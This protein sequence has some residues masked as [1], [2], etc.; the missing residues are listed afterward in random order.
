MSTPIRT[1][2]PAA[3]A[4]ILSG[5]AITHNI[6]PVANVDGKQLCI[7]EN[8]GV[9]NQAF[10]AT[11]RRVLQERGYTVRMLPPASPVASC[12]LTSTYNA[13]WQQDF[14]RYLAF[15]DLRIFVG[16]QQVGYAIY[17]STGGTFNKDKFIQ[18]DAKIA[19]L[20]GAMLPDAR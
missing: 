5:C 18:D 4:A 20:V 11:Y 12:R 13:S 2:V 15:A 7:V 16:G 10:V 19:E 9:T 17:D 14:K 3:I 6:G 1:A 8:L